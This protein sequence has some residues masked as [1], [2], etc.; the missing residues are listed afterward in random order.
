[1][2][3]PMTSDELRRYAELIV[4]GCIAFRR[5]DT[6][7]IRSGLAH[8]ELAAALTGAA[9]RAGAFGV[10]VEYEDGHLYAERIMHASKEALGRRT[11][12]QNERLRALGDPRTRGA[13]MPARRCG[14]RRSRHR[15]PA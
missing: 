6:L 13:Q 8:R 4:H 5:G 14:R 10:D 3:T 11:S 9:Y 15:A 2:L 7:L 12:W 1:M